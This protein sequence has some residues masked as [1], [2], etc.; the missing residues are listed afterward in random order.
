MEHTDIMVKNLATRAFY[1]RVLTLLQ[2][3]AIPF[4]IGGSFALRHYTGIARQT[5]DLDIFLCERDSHHA[6]AVLSEAGYRT[7]VTSPI[8]LGKVFGKAAFIDLLFGSANGLIAVDNEWFI[9][10]KPARILDL[11]VQVCAPEELIW[12]KAYVMNRDRYDGAD[13]THLVRAQGKVID[14]RRLLQHFGDHWPVLFSH[15][16]LINFVYPFEPD[17]I[18]RWVLHECLH[19]MQHAADTP[20]S[21]PPLCRGSLLSAEQYV[22]DLEEWGYHD[23]RMIPYGN[24]TDEVTI[25]LREA[26]K[27]QSGG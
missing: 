5:K 16:I 24:L 22:I 12:S 20:Q 4:L 9:H 1:R 25:A 26:W 10:A 8:W 15:L 6:L 3:Q 13:I 18:P 27:T 11:D 7:E 14:W 2:R 19:R 17:L 23:A 21:G